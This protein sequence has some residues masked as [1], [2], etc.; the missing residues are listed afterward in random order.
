MKPAQKQ[1]ETR[2]FDGYV[3]CL[4]LIQPGSFEK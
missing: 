3:L 1:Q 4:L 2:H